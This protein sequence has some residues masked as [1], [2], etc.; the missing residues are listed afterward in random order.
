VLNLKRIYFLTLLFVFICVNIYSNTFINY[1]TKEENRNEVFRNVV[2]KHLTD[3]EKLTFLI[4]KEIANK[5]LDEELAA[6][7]ILQLIKPYDQ[8]FDASIDKM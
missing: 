3:K 6:Q 8:K 4:R 1:I 5:I 2:F 7:Y